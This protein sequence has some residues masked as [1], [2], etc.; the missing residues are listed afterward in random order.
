MANVNL[1]GRT[2]SDGVLNTVLENIA[3]YFEADLNVTSGDRTFVP[4]GG[5]TTSLHLSK[6]AADF[7][8]TGLTLEVVYLNLRNLGANQV[9]VAGHAYEFIWHGPHTATTG[10]HLHLGRISTSTGGYVKFIKEGITPEGS[11]KY[12]VDLKVTLTGSIQGLLQAL[13]N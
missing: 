10:A 12:P 13:P 9:F 2:V 8:I 1:N 4:E 3:K 7:N 6:R 5:S 11:G